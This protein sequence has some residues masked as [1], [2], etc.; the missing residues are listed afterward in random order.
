ML[1]VVVG[2][3]RYCVSLRW[4]LD[5]DLLETVFIVRSLG[6][7]VH[8]FGF[9]PATNG[10]LTIEGIDRYTWRPA[11]R[12]RS[13]FLR[14]ESLVINFASGSADGFALHARL[15]TYH[16]SLRALHFPLRL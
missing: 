11:H 1:M 10:H 9:V 13:R 16:L 3:E 15:F 12:K 6:G 8:H 7:V 4:G 5:R 2:S 14:R